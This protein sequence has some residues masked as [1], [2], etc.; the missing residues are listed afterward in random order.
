MPSYVFKCYLII[1]L[2]I[3]CKF[4]TF[5]NS[6]IF[7]LENSELGE[8][9]KIERDDFPAVIVFVKNNIEGMFLV[10]PRIVFIIV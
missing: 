9:F 1:Y 10:F 3:Y 6:C 8:R 4:F 2:N 7:F 5:C